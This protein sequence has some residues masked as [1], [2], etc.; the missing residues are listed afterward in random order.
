MNKATFEQKEKALKAVG[1]NVTIED[2]EHM[3]YEISYLK[4]SD[5]DMY[6]RFLDLLKL[7]KK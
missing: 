6:H 1:V 2:N 5:P 3:D 4:D 7:M